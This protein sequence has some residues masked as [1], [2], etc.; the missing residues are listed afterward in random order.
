MPLS[1]PC[2][3]TQACV[4]LFIAQKHFSQKQTGLLLNIVNLLQ[5]LNL[6]SISCTFS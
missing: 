1:D 2:L 4:L 5:V 3:L 6:T